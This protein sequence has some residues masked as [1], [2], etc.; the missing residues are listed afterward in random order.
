M[1]HSPFL[2]PGVPFVLYNSVRIAAPPLTILSAYHLANRFFG[3]ALSSWILALVCLFST[4]GLAV[5]YIWNRDR[6]YEREAVK[7]GA[8]LPPRVRGKLPGNFDV[9]LMFGHLFKTGYLG[10]EFFNSQLSR[11]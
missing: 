7:M 4:P 5:L 3:V 9:L 11:V 2:P 8:T 6:T 10:R 1:P